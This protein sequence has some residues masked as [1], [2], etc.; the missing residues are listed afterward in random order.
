M[1]FQKRQS[2]GAKIAR[3]RLLIPRFKI[4][5]VPRSRHSHEFVRDAVLREHA[6]K[7]LGLR[8]VDRQVDL[9]V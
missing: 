5:R 8:A 7:F 3:Q 4:E 2:H 1:L 6:R 9:A